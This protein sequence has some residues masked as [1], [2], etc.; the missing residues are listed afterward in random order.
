M[1]A[2]KTNIDKQVSRHRGPLFGLMAVGGFV[3]VL[4]LGWL[5]YESYGTR[6]AT[7]VPPAETAPA[8]G[9]SGTTAPASEDSESAAPAPDD[10]AP[11]G[12]TD[13]A[14]TGSAPTTPPAPET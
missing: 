12:T 14:P 11:S 5:F 10:V 8:A 6:D 3:G 9:T 13:P 4:L 7:D 2:P 1:S